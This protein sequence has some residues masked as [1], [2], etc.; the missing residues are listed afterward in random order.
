M[1]YKKVIF[2]MLLCTIISQNPTFGQFN[3]ILPGKKVEVKPSTIISTP[4][5]DTVSATPQQIISEEDEPIEFQDVVPI[6]TNTLSEA[7]IVALNQYM[8]LPLDTIFITSPYGPRTPPIKG[9]SSNHKGIDLKGHN[10]IVYAIMAGRIKKTGKNKTLGNY[11]IIQHG[12]FISIYGHLSSVL[13]TPKQTIMAG[14][15]IGI[16]GN[17]GITTGEH[18]HFAMKY[19]DAFID[20]EPFVRLTIAIKSSQQ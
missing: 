19:K 4:P 3:T 8:S 7:R 15:I 9:A 6:D 14:Q 5:I 2:F 12:D 20:P 16:T 11:I 1:Y 13:V 18:L 17:T 10:S